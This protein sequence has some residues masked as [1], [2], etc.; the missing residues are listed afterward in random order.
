MKS[1]LSALT[2][3]E[4]IVGAK[5]TPDEMRAFAHGLLNEAN[6]AEMHEKNAFLYLRVEMSEEIGT[7]CDQIVGARRLRA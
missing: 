6:A 2:M 1:F 4:V 7:L 5:M 3:E